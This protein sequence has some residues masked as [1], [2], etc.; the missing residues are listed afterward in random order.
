MI[1]QNTKVTVVLWWC[2]GGAVVVLWWCCG[3]AVVVLWWCC[4]GAVVV[5]WW[6]CGARSL[7]GED[8]FPAGPQAFLRWFQSGRNRLGRMKKM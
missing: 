1:R 7:E 6:C 2:C 3:G 8:R 4:G 5:L